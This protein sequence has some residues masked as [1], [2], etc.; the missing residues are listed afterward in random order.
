VLLFREFIVRKHERGLLF[1]NGDFQRF[2][3]PAVYRFF[4]PRKRLDVERFDLTHA[5]FEHPLLDYLVRWH[6]ESVEDLFLRVE[7]VADQVA[8]VYRNGH[9]WTMVG[10]DER[11][12]FWKG[13][14]QLKAEL[15]D[16]AH[17]I[18]VAPRLVRAV[19]TALQARRSSPFESAVLVREVPE[20][21]VG[22]LY[23]DGQLVRE[24]S[25]GLH[26]FWRYGRHVSVELVDLRV[27]ALQVA[28]HELI[29]KDQ[30]CLRVYLAAN[31]RF[32]DAPLTVRSVRD[33]MAL[34][35]S[36][37]RQ[38]LRTAVATRSLEAVLEDKAGVDQD[39]FRRVRDKFATLGIDV[40]DIGVNELVR[41]RL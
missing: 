14:L 26:G 41:I 36:E 38:G 10:P 2:L 31:Y 35:D 4:D 21:H 5:R 24:L 23:V 15:V 18:A 19:V 25:P 27:K 22:L 20:A 11:V 16:I 37:I 40:R 32:T 7:T 28:E 9:P 13:V 12:L 34:L 30:A 39:V 33:P 8:V 29:T 1:R 17:D 6:P 3:A